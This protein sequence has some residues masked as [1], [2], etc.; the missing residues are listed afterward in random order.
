MIHATPRTIPGALLLAI[1][2]AVVGAPQAR[3]ASPQLV[4][5]DEFNGPV[6]SGPDP[7]K[8]VYDL[9]GGGWGNNELETYT[10]SR[11][12]SLIV[13]DP[14]ATDGKALAIRAQYANGGYTS[15]R[16]NTSMTFSFEYGR[17]EARARVPAGIGCW[18]AFWALGSDISTVGW[19][20]CGE[21]DV[22]EWV[23]QTPGTIYGSLH[24]PGFSG[25]NAETASISLPGGAS[26]SDAYHV[27]AVDWYP[28]EIVF[29]VDGTVYEVRLQS[30]IP[31]GSSWPFSQNFFILLNFAVGGNWPGSPDSQTVFPQ[32]YRVDYVR[33]YTLPSTPP[34]NLVW[35]PSPPLG[36]SAYFSAAS[37]VNVAWQPPFSTFGAAVLGY[38][39]QR[40]GDP[41]FT[42]GLTS[43]DLGNVTSFSDTSAVAGA[44]YYYRVSAVSPNGTSDPSAG[45]QASVLTPAADS[46]LLNISTRGFVGTGA[47]MLIAGFYVAGP[48]QK[49]VLIRASG[50]AL[51]AFG[52][53]GV[54]PDPA[55][56]V[57]SGSSVIASNTGWGGNAQIV[58]AASA[59][60][61]FAWTDPKSADSALLL[62]LAPGQ[63]T[64]I[65]SGAGGDTGVSLVE[66]YDPNLPGEVSK[67]TNI[68]TRG[69]VG[70]GSD[71]VI[72]GFVVGGEASKTALVRASGPVLS[73][74]GVSGVLPDP[75][76]QVYNGNSV[77]ASNNGWGAN[78]QIA[79]AASAVGAFSWG[80]A[81][82]ND[83]ALLLTL[84]P[85]QYTAIVSGANADTGV[86]LVEVYDVP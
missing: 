43:W 78:A 48:T 49:T 71:L 11:N 67:L 4:W 60:G 17:L 84:P 20:A 9:G 50:P 51:S 74:L 32:D 36:L 18:P 19:P 28:G 65:V 37:Q 85:G 16:I 57:Y 40:A 58:A 56:Q 69:F 12:N 22:M 59:A 39:L 75:N 70:T 3:A 38:V 46:K 72:A 63:Y 54:L 13:S 29:S 62:S 7:S 76:L 8:W 14:L 61:A 41:A 30:D 25:G 27:F 55:L 52:V 77:I 79:A 35:P 86:A 15:A 64:A 10:N 81:S 82:T 6:G 26:F 33:V 66:V 42:Q 24:A 80:N 44:T 21:I 5:N 83:S 23:G 73:Q 47:D 53:S 45:I 68:S 1:S 2:L 31:A 34:Q